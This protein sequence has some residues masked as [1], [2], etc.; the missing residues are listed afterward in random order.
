MAT[1]PS[2]IPVR[3]VLVGAG[4][5]GAIGTPLAVIFVWLMGTFGHP[6]PAEVAG[7]ISSLITVAVSFIASYI[8]PPEEPNTA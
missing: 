4:A 2:K 5:G 6:I 1:S 3:K 7:A 8:V